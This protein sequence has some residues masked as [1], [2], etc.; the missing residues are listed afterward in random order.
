MNIAIFSPNKNPYSETFIQAH[1]SGLRNVSYYFGK[2]KK[3]FLEGK[4]KIYEE[5][6]CKAKIKR[7]LLRRDKK[8]LWCQ[9]KDNLKLNEIDV[10]LIEYG[11]HAHNLLPLLKIVDIP[12]V[13]HFHGYDASVKKVVET[14]NF[15]KEVFDISQG[16]IAVSIQMKEMLLEIGCPIRKIQLNTYGP[17]DIFFN[18]ESSFKKMQFIGIGRFTDKK[19]PYYTIMAFHKTLVSHPDAKLILAGDGYLLNSCINLVKHL[20][21]QDSVNFP[22]VIT[23]DEFIRYLEE[24]YAFVQHSITALSGDMEGTPVAV[25]EAAAAG[26]PVI[27][28]LHAGIPDVIINNETGLLC[29]EHDVNLMSEHMIAIL[30]NKQKAIDMG[31][32]SRNNIKENF[33]MSKHIGQIQGILYQVSNQI[34]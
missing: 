34:K 8:S 25:L 5:E 30:S 22:G 26:L 10:I 1:K 9:L 11:T 20:G 2:E 29:E 4:G 3:I 33:D 24:S 7:K 28:T 14:N 32:A 23:A 27:S 15:Y 16:I 21:I 17:R 18:V 12:V 6:S 31:R 19:A 13:V